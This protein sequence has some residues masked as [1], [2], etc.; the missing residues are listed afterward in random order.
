V[1]TENH[2]KP[3]F[4]KISSYGFLLESDPKLPSVCSIITGGPLK[5]SWWSHPLAQTI[6]QVNEKLEDHP[7]VLMTKLVSGKVTFV[8]RDLW[9][10]I[11]AIGSSYET[12]QMEGLSAS[13][14]TLLKMVQ[15]KGTVQTDQIVLTTSDATRKIKPGDAAREL[16]RKILIHTDQIHTTGG[17]HA[18][19][20]ET[21][22]HWSK[23]SAFAHASIAI[24]PAKRKL[25]AR[26]RKLNNE[27]GGTARLPWSAV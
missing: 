13:A 24:D 7:D 16:E 5:G 26:I 2:F 22:Q 11:L 19:V 17:A 3:V 9:P 23:R 8:H 15:A 10:E 12:W 1:T 25:E 18:K 4:S 14:Q 20:L 21:W 27:F 6:F